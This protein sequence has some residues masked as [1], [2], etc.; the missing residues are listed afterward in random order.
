[1]EGRPCR[2]WQST[3]VFLPGESHGQRSPAGYSPWGRRESDTA[4]SSYGLLVGGGLH[5]VYML[6]TLAGLTGPHLVHPLAFFFFFL[7]IESGTDVQ[8][9][10]L[11]GREYPNVISPSYPVHT[12]QSTPKEHLE[13][14]VHNF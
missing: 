11:E 3:P 8:R 12:P 13:L 14:P 1:M 9:C 7:S 4:G 2:K 6:R 5:Q 10:L